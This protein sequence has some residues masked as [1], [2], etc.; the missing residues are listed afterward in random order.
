MQALIIADVHANLPA[1]E[2]VLATPEAQACQRMISLGDQVN[3]GPQP[4]QVLLRLKELNAIMLL[5]NHEARL[6]RANAPE[7]AG[8]NWAI[9]RWTHKQ[10]QDLSFAFPVDYAE[11]AKL[12]THGTPGDPFHL[13]EA[14]QVPALLDSLPNHVTHL[15]SGHN[16]GPW[17]VE[18]R[19][20][21]ACNPGSLGMLE[22]G[23]GGRAPFV[24]MEEQNG[25]IRLTRHMA[26]YDTTALKRAFI[27]SG[28]ATAAPE[29][30]RIVL[31]TM[32]HGEYQA[33]LKLM[34]FIAHLG[35]LADPATWQQAD[36]AWPWRE[37][38]PTAK[39]WKRLEEELF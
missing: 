39:Y 38:F 13:M 2:A 7:F 17:L 36:R 30:A 12:F 34:R 32:L 3:F 29:M 6:L 5:G 1:L 20:R 28:C 23:M 31:H 19:G 21:I 22:D 27:E 35:D 26:T 8:C 37:P 15:F 9:Q 11:D 24:V 18:H 16:H 14:S 10:I 4:R 33:T 25:S